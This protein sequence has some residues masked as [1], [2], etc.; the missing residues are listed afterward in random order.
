M[1]Q[2]AEAFGQHVVDDS[3]DHCRLGGLPRSAAG[4]LAAV[5]ADAPDRRCRVTGGGHHRRVDREV[6]VALQRTP[7]ETAAGHLIDERQEE[8]DGET[9][10]RPEPEG[11]ERA[12]LHRVGVEEDDLDVE[13]DEQHRDDVEAHH[14]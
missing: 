14:L 12:T 3:H 10:D 2:P 11:A 13:H 5:E 8:Y 6:A 9:E 1:R 7:V 4:R